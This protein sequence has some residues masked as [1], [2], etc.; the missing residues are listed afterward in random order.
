MND[1]VEELLEALPEYYPNIFNEDDIHRRSVGKVISEYW[2]IYCNPETYDVLLGIECGDPETYASEEFVSKAAGI[3]Q[4]YY[5]K[6]FYNLSDIVFNL[7]LRL[8]EIDVNPDIVFVPRW[9]VAHS[10]KCQTKV[11]HFL[12]YLKTVETKPMKYV[13]GMNMRVHDKN[14][15]R[16]E[17]SL[18]GVFREMEYRRD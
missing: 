6:H 8:K 3:I 10:I 17:S 7:V 9:V 15:V 14:I 18:C 4:G 2:H 5:V 16:V 12:S 1:Y 13:Y 11:G